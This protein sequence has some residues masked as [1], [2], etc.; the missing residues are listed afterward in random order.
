MHSFDGVGGKCHFPH[1][2][3]WW[4]SLILSFFFLPN[5]VIIGL[6]LVFALPF[7]WFLQVWS[8]LRQAIFRLNSLSFLLSSPNL[9]ST[10][11]WHT[12]RQVFLALL[13]CR[14]WTQRKEGSP[15]RCWPMCP[16]EQEAGAVVQL[17]HRKSLLKWFFPKVSTGVV[18]SLVPVRVCVWWD[19]WSHYHLGE[20]K[21]WRELW[22][23]M[24]PMSGNQSL[25]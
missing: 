21:Q 14:P 11:A 13:S 6:A 18:Q 19:G 5:L 24:C 3:W 16:S 8:F 15:V 2:A 7:T 10:F 22:K 9:I 4:I 17:G 23:S 12:K 1:L 20:E 25:H